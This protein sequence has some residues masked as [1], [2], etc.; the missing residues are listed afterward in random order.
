MQYK[1]NKA[2]LPTTRLIDLYYRNEECRAACSHCRNYG[3]Q[4]SCPPFAVDPLAQL[5]RFSLATILAVE[6]PVAPGTPS[7][8]AIDVMAPAHP[9]LVEAAMELER[10][11][12]GRAS[13]TACAQN[14]A[15]GRMVCHADI[16]IEC[17]PLPK[18]SA[19]TL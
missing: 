13:C 19:L 7:D 3:R 8:R 14:P 9:I 18:H 17:V 4:W 16:Q 2:T 6:I 5:S 10:Q 1:L 15:P 12:G 11:T